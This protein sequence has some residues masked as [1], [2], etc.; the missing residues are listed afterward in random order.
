MSIILAEVNA[1]ANERLDAISATT[2]VVTPLSGTW[3]FS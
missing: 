2:W 3:T 1:G